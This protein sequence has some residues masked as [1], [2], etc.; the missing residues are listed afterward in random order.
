MDKRIVS[1]IWIY[2]VKSLGGIRLRSSKVMP[3]GLE[4]D[5]RWMLIDEEN[6]FMTQRAFPQMALFKLSYE[7]RGFIIR[8]RDQLIDL[9]FQTLHDLISARIWKDTVDVY[10]VSKRHN[11]WFSKNI[12]INCRLVSFPENNPRPVE[13]GFSINND[14]VSLADA[15]PLLIIGQ[16]SLDDLNGRLQKPLPVNRFRPNIVFTGGQPYEEDDW[17]NFRVGKNR[18]TGVKSCSR[19]SITTINQDTAQ[20]GIEPLATLATYRRR[21]NNVY[22]GKDLIPLNYNEIAEGEEI[23]VE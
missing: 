6:N 7:P 14:H 2:P 21:D 16:S 18:F 17:G 3:K 15:Y 12:G 10:E 19:C 20:K 8:Y 1:E 5:R 11:D 13:P 22:F 23:F 4:Y 9:S